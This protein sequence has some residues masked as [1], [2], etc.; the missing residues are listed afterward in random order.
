MFLVVG[1][2]RQSQSVSVAQRVQN[3]SISAYWMTMF[4]LEGV[5]LSMAERF[6]GRLY[7]QVGRA[8]SVRLE[9]TPA[10]I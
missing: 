3:R 5:P 8:V 4:R 9:R 7:Q 2:R 10:D 6:F 1:L